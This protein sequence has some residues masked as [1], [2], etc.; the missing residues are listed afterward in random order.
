RGGEFA[1]V[2]LPTAC[3]CVTLVQVLQE[4]GEVA[5]LDSWTYHGFGPGVV[6]IV[7]AVGPTFLERGC[8]QEQ[9]A[10]GIARDGGKRRGVTSGLKATGTKRCGRQG[11]QGKTSF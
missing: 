2:G 6:R 9:A 7:D 3:H 4:L 10:F 1:A 8:D 11:D 5:A